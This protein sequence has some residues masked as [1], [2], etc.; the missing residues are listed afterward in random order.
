MILPV[1]RLEDAAGKLCQALL[2]IR[3]EYYL[4]AG[5]GV[6]ICTLSSI[7]LLETVSRSSL[8]NKVLI[9]GRL[10]SENKG[11]DAIISFAIKHPELKRLI[12]CGKEVK[13]HRAG[14]ALLALTINGMDSF[15]RIIGAV[16][17]NP[18]LMSSPPDVEI[19]RH[20][21]QIINLIGAVD[22]ARIA[23]VLIS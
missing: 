21:V 22:T 2:P 11:I 18:V 10:L 9:V 8:M 4:G 16:G 15:G 1:K 23:Q 6:A 5:N 3:H 7:D 13:G 19:F 20:Q 17:P 12:L 14:Q